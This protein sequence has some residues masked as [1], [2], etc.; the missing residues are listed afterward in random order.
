[1]LLAYIYNND[2]TTSIASML[3]VNIQSYKYIKSLVGWWGRKKSVLK[4]HEIKNFV[5]C[6]IMVRKSLI[7]SV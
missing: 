2:Y 7:L 3:I 4:M 1:M 5:V 6:I